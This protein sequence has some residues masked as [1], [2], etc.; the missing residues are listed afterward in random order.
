MDG[1][2]CSEWFS[3]TWTDSHTPFDLDLLGIEPETLK[4]HLHPKVKGMGYEDWAGVSLACDPKLLSQ[5]ALL[6]RWAK[7]RAR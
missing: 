4:V 5:D 1:L 3:R 2:P 7:F 6:S